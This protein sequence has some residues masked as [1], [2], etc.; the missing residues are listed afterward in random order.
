MLL[1]QDQIYGEDEIQHLIGVV[2]LHQEFSNISQ[3]K[4]K[5]YVTICEYP[6]QQTYFLYSTHDSVMT[7]IFQ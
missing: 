1:Y 7:M 2:F 4:T 6:V 5:L 3:V